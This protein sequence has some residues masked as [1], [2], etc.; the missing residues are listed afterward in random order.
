[1]TGGGILNALKG[2]S[3]EFEINRVVGAIGG[4]GYINGALAFTAWDVMWRGREFDIVAFCTA[5]PGGLGII[6]GAIA[7]A[8]AYKDKGVATAKVIEQTGSAPGL[9]ASGSVPKDAGEAARQTAEAANREA[10]DIEGN[11]R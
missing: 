4:I 10:E 9:A 11:V 1:M 3:G 6:V 5:F 7:G 8:S 2:I